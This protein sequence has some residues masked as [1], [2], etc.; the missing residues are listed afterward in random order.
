MDPDPGPDR[1]HE[2]QPL[3]LGH[4]SQQTHDYKSNGTTT[5]FAALDVHTGKVS[6]NAFYQRHT[7]SEF[8]DFLGQVAAVHPDVELHVICDN[9]ATQKH[10]NVKDWLA[11]NPRVS[12]HF[13]PT[14]CSWLTMVEIFF[15][16]VTRQAIRRG[17]FHSVQDL[18][19][20]IETY[21]ANYNDR[22]KPFRWIKTADYLLGKIKRKQTINT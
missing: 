20:T 19:Q 16:L 10:Q 12:L 1:T 8:V 2:N 9:Y 3:F 14:S 13:T 15:G 5:L 4:A 17:S 7:N 22:A 6:A 21:I 11:A 18:G